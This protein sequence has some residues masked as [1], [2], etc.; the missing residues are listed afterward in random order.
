MQFGF[1]AAQA[2][3]T[4]APT[5]TGTMALPF[6]PWASKNIF[7]MPYLKA[8]SAPTPTNSSGVASVILQPGITIGYGFN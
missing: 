5:I 7:I 3:S 6:K 1:T 2:T 4:V 8:L